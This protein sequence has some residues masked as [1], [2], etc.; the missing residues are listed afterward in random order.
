[1]VDINIVHS[2]PFSGFE[3]ILRSGRYFV[4]RNGRNHIFLEAVE[5]SYIHKKI[6]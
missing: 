3:K 5:I 4:L 1:M 6:I 2:L